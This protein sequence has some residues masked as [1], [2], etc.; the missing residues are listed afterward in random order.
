[1]LKLKTIE[2]DVEGIGYIR[3]SDER[4]DKEDISEQTQLSKIQAYCDY[5][6][7]KLVKVFKDIDYS[8]FRISYTKRP[9]IMEAL[10]YCREHPKI[11][12]FILFNLSRLT[13]RKKDFHLIQTALESISV[14]ICSA[15]EQLDFGSATGR[16]VTSVLVD[17]NEYY[18]DNLS[19]VVT[20]NKQTNAEKG[21]WNGGPAPFGM[22]KNKEKGLSPDG[23]NAILVRD[24]FRL[25][26]EGKGPYFIAKWLRSKN[27]LTKTGVSWTAR[28]VRYMLTNCTYAG[29]QKWKGKLYALANTEPLISWDEFEYLQKTRF[30]KENVWRGMHNRQLLTTI[31]RCPHCGSKMSSRMTTAKKRRNYVC[32]NKNSN[33]RCLSPNF[34]TESLDS[35]V[36][37]LIGVLAKE[38]YQTEHI[39]PELTDQKEPG[40]TSIKKL[41]NEL[42]ILEQAK[43]KVFDDYYL[44]QKFDEAQFQNLMLRYD[45]RQKEVARKLEK[46]P[47]PTQNNYGELDDVIDLFAEAIEVLEPDEKRK[48]VG[49]I[50]EKI[51]PGNPAIVEFRWG[52]TREIPAK[53]IRY[54][55]RNVVY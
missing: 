34:D 15:S 10:K 38:R 55:N 18:S 45:T 46:I 35:A 16:L 44:H 22:I 20:A 19:D 23:E 53:A 4:D 42:T 21:R 52:E 9:G 3:Q 30:S 6:G 26:L 27:L 48:A 28:R 8:G 13:R 5:N 12:K 47:L 39:L 1:M 54:G 29:W 17:F 32:D 24:S 50:V 43:Q 49:L 2:E 51:V 40:L 11:K 14:D 25:A 31:M 33:G 37:N 41:Q 36:I 7:I